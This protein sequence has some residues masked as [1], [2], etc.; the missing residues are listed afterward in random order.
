MID[1]SGI[2]FKYEKDIIFNDVSF[3]IRKGQKVALIGP[4]GSGKTTLFMLI[5]G[6]LKPEHGEIAIDRQKVKHVLF[7]PSVGYLFQSPDDQLFS[8]TVL[9]DAAFGPLNMGQ[10]TQ[11]AR[12]N[13]EAALDQVG[14]GDVRQKSPH[15]LSGGQKRLAA[16]SGLMAMECDVLLLDEPTSNLD[17][18][19]RRQIIN[20]LNGMDKTMM[21]ASHDLEFLLEVCDRC[22]LL[23]QGRI[24]ANGPIKEIL[25]NPTLLN[26]HHMEQPH[27]LIPHRHQQSV[28]GVPVRH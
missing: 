12:K 18:R 3:T 19:N 23:N 17:A 6:V 22:I 11:E 10:S 14:L 20:L 2:V 16:L 5:N 8:G 27:S 21:V 4:N 28:I 7:N 15:Q 26:E 13:A 1:I 24:I 9:D 25:S